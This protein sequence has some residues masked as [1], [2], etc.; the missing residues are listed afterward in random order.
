[1]DGP[2]TALPLSKSGDTFR[3]DI[4][5]LRSIAVLLVIGCHCGIS[6]CAGGF[7]G[8]DV[9]FVISGYLITGLLAREYLET[10][11][12]DFA[13]FFARRARRLLPACL[14]VLASTALAAALLLGPQEIDS[15]ARA[16]L[17]GSL[18][19][20]NIFFDHA[21]SD[22]FAPAV[23]QNPLL[24]TW[25]L[26]VEEQFY[27]V[28]P[29]LIL[30]AGR[31]ARARP[32]IFAALAASSFAC[33]LLATR[34]AP[35]FAFYEL[36]A[37]AWEFAA[38]GILAL[39][40]AVGRSGRSGIW[41]VAGGIV[42]AVMIVGT[43]FRVKGGS[44]FPGW[45]A[46]VP[47]AGTLLVLS[48]GDAEPHRGVSA[49]LSTAPLRFLGAR[50]YSWYLWHWPFVVFAAVLLPAITVVQ[51]IEAAIAALLMAAL[52]HR[53]VEQPIRTSRH[54]VRRPN[55]SLCAAA[56]AALL[57]IGT[58]A[59]L[60]S[61]GQREMT[62]DAKYEAI[63]A[64]TV[65]YGFAARQCY[66]DG[67]SVEAVKAMVCEF[68]D[69]RAA[70]TLVLF[71]DSHAMQ[72]INAMRKAAD[73]K[74]WHLV[75][76]V[77]P[78]CAASDIN[79]HNL[80]VPSDACK[81]WRVQAIEKIVDL[82]PYAVVMAS[83]NGATVQ[84]DML[85]PSLMPVDEV[86]A[87]T[88]S[89]LLKLRAAG[90]RVVVLRDSPHPPFN[91]PACISRSIGRAHSTV[92]P[93]EFDASKALNASAF[94]AERAAGEGL[95]DVYYLDMDDLICP[96]ASCSAVQD[97]RIVY[98][99]ENH[100]AGSYAESLAGEVAARLSRVLDRAPTLAHRSGD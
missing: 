3:A 82:V 21:S 49:V 71:G 5:G 35:T 54:L 65:D 79:P 72:W 81:L 76:L 77:K 64:A 31:S 17:A 98:R 74:G 48:A 10:L 30:F 39:A 34:N 69:P 66:T 38:G 83:Y 45:I 4:E 51:K 86:R 16:G 7:V 61:F 88:R 46:L 75:T 15:T 94:E 91:V 41:S 27:L 96:G 19:M 2:Q 60:A 11:G 68:G 99:D 12:I 14:V 90:I 47:V 9:F 23:Q 97:G 92:D 37:R 18:Y 32:W 29:W 52:S 80:S 33:A 13:A 55:W 20:S 56:G 36:P 28:W 40:P 95:T 73:E 44:G 42:G 58:S 62:L 53:W 63:Q 50:S 84:G 85:T 24:H 22:Y 78:G 1:M 87:G 70:R 26:G 8:V 93:C 89:I 59:A 67:R 25:S 57:T 43:M 6:W 100:L